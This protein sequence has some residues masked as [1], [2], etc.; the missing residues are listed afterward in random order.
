MSNHPLNMM[1]HD[2]SQYGSM[3]FGAPQQS[4]GIS[5]LTQTAAQ[6]ASP[7]GPMYLPTSTALGP[8]NEM[9]EG[10]GP[11]GAIAGLGVD[12]YLRNQFATAGLIPYGDAGSFYQAQEIERFREASLAAMT[13]SDQDQAAIDRLFR[14]AFKLAGRDVETFS[15]EEAENFQQLISSTHGMMAIA[16]MLP[17]GTQMIDQLAGPRG[18][19]TAM[20]QQMLPAS[21]FQIDPLTGQMGIQ[22]DTLI[23]MRDELFRQ[24]Y[25]EDSTAETLGLRAGEMGSLYSTLR[26][27]GL[28]GGGPTL[29]ESVQQALGAVG[30]DVR[31]EAL[32]DTS[33]RGTDNFNV[34][35][36]TD[37]SAADL[38]KVAQNPAMS[39]Q[40][41][42]ATMTQAAERLKG[43]T[44]SV[45]AIG[46]MF[47]EHGKDATIPELMNALKALTGNRLQ[48]FTDD[49]LTGMVNDIQA[50]TRVTP[51]SVDQV[52]QANQTARSLL[53]AS[54]AGD[55]A[56]QFAHGVAMSGIAAGEVSR[57]RALVGFGM[58]NPEEARYFRMN[59]DS[60]FVNSEMA[61]NLATLSRLRD[62][63]GSDFS[64]GDANAMF[65]A[66]VQGKATY[67][68]AEGREVA[69]PKTNTQFLQRLSAMGLNMDAFSTVQQ[70]R[71][72]NQERLATR[73]ELLEAGKGAQFSELMTKVTRSVQASLPNLNVDGKLMDDVVTSLEGLGNNITDEPA[74]RRAV[75]KLLQDQ[76]GLGPETADQQAL[77]L[78]AAQS[79]AIS[80]LVPG[81]TVQG[82]V[83]TMGPAA[84]QREAE[85]RRTIDLKSQLGEALRPLGKSGT[86][87]EKI[88]AAISA[89]GG[90]ED[91][92]IETIINEVLGTQSGEETDG[93]TATSR[94][95]AAEQ[96][97]KIT[98]ESYIPV[99][100]D[101]ARLRVMNQDSATR[102]ED[103][104]KLEAEIEANIE[105]LKTR[106]EEAKKT[107]GLP[108]LQEEFEVQALQKE[109][110]DQIKPEN[111]VTSNQAVTFPD[112]FV[113]SGKLT[114][115]NFNPDTG[116]AVARITQGEANPGMIS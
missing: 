50:V 77:E 60:R 107:G 12:Q 51:L 47:S 57:D 63:E 101:I 92:N 3:G 35:D 70:D 79:T 13:S 81:Q 111:E 74:R 91:P 52:F 38:L 82:V 24:M 96:L 68:T 108:A 56:E 109:V 11:L 53:V 26:T 80:A 114:I 30:S 86:L 75:S 89:A 65:E 39:E 90:Q 54:G 66:A 49:Q 62:V 110:A 88:A 23:K 71:A 41:I 100:K 78:L 40:V 55:F 36:I 84:Q 116:E 19:T 69:V 103:R 58:L 93:A 106:V 25:E 33:R 29:R 27:E 34:D 83:A 104:D 31:R 67:T 95:E 20:G 8:L 16:S 15:V 4:T 5:Y 64:T 61:N 32:Q 115:E 45:Q 21:R 97:R 59:L 94:K 14:G 6:Y 2:L 7:A 9:L 43:Y 10:M 37:L 28:I 22:G 42:R 18:S 105:A 85:L 1:L 76:R 87:V 99:R 98:Q 48:R 113:I 102:P 112:K 44:R 73:P 72:G 46:E 17:G